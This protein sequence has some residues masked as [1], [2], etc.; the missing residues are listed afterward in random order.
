M[1]RVQRLIRRVVDF[2]GVSRLTTVQTT[3]LYSFTE[4]ALHAHLLPIK[5]CVS[6]WHGEIACRAYP[7]SC[8]PNRLALRPGNHLRDLKGSCRVKLRPGLSPSLR[9]R[10]R[11][12]CQ[13][14]HT[15]RFQTKWNTQEAR[16]THLKRVRTDLCGQTGTPRVFS[17]R[18]ARAAAV[19]VFHGV[20]CSIYLHP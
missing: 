10:V 19:A 17:N 11:K 6:H 4:P 18:A 1:K 13:N 16:K 8:R 9:V 3:N 15:L 7:L 5:A 12:P 14:G 2:G 20:C